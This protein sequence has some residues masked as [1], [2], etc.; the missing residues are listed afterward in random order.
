MT[1]RNAVATRFNRATDRSDRLAEERQ[2]ELGETQLRAIFAADADGT[3]TRELVEQARPNI[4]PA[5]YRTALTMLDPSSDDLVDDEEAVIDL[6]GRMTTENIGDLAAGYL[7]RGLLTTTT[8]RTITEQNRKYLANRNPDNPF[9]ATRKR[10]ED[11]LDPTGLLQGAGAL[12]ARIARSNALAEYDL[13]FL[14]HPDATRSEV[15]EEGS[16]IIRNFQVIDFSTMSLTLGLPR[17]F[18][19][20][21]DDLTLSDIDEAEDKVIDAHA[22]GRLNNAAFDEELRKLENWRAVLN[23]KALID[24][25]APPPSGRNRTNPARPER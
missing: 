18:T 12:A 1:A 13:F 11:T 4:T 8:F 2:K 5:E 25:S 21:R 23:R 14:D 10:I 22:D 15:Q 19:G 9:K 16:R 17:F 6:I 24:S 20:S 3:L 7:R